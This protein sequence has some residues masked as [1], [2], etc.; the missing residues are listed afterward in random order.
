[1]QGRTHPIDLGEVDELLNVLP[2]PRHL[3]AIA[4][5]DRVI[6]DK[7]AGAAGLE[8]DPLAACR[9]NVENAVADLRDAAVDDAEDVDRAVGPARE[10][11]AGIRDVTG[12]RHLAAG[13]RHN[14]RAGAD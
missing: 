12:R 2:E 10:Q 3:A 14:D 1:M 13:G 6:E 5:G 8:F 11:S 7:S 9:F 4:A